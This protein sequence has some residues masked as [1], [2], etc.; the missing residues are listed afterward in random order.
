MADVQRARSTR[1]RKLL[2]LDSETVPTEPRTAR[3][4]TSEPAPH[5]L[6]G[7]L[8]LL[9]APAGHPGRSTREREKCL[10]AHKIPGSGSTLEKQ[11][12]SITTSHEHNLACTSFTIFTSEST[13]KL[14]RC[15]PICYCTSKQAAQCYATFTRYAG[16]A[17]PKTLTT[18]AQWRAF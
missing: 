18:W 7:R 2:P 13:P 6:P 15:L 3:L 8:F 17:P 5:L 16:K 9:G 14:P 12:A 1:L 11:W 10:K 4:P